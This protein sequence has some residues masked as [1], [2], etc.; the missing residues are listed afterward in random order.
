MTLPLFLQVFYVD[1]LEVQ[2]HKLA[3]TGIIKFRALL[4]LS[5]NFLQVSLSQ[6][7]TFIG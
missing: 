3:S 1:M 7:K 2:I 4:E 5:N 6:H